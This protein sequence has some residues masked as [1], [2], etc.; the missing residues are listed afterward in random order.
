LADTQARGL[1]PPDGR[2]LPSELGKL[3]KHVAEVEGNCIIGAEQLSRSAMEI[4]NT[5]V[6]F[7]VL[8]IQEI[9]LQLQSVR[10]DMVAFSLVLEW[11]CEE[12]LVHEPDA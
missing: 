4:S 11:L 2:D 9:P 6:D 5:L 3:R 10:D 7:N 12:V 8:P 1:Y